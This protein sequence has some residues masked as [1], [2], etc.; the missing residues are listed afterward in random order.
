MTGPCHEKNI[1]KKMNMQIKMIIRV[2]R[3]HWLTDNFLVVLKYCKGLWYEHHVIPYV[4]LFYYTK[5]IVAWAIE[6][7]FFF[8]YSIMI[9][10]FK[11]VSVSILAKIK[12]MSYWADYFLFCTVYI[13][14][15]FEYL[16][17]TFQSDA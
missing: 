13:L 2:Q 11:N 3:A 10:L 4:I 12:N 7:F 6:S 14:S 1:R 16:R 5:T 9:T 15:I 8:V 17:C